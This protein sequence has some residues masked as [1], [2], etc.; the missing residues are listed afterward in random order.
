MTYLNYEKGQSLFDSRND[1]VMKT[2][3]MVHSFMIANQQM[4]PDRLRPSKPFDMYYFYLSL[5]QV[6]AE[7]YQKPIP[8]FLPEDCKVLAFNRPDFRLGS[9]IGFPFVDLGIAAAYVDK[10]EAD[11]DAGGTDFDLDFA[12]KVACQA[13]DAKAI[14]TIQNGSHPMEDRSGDDLESW[15]SGFNVASLEKSVDHN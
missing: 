11:S 14:K 2:S 4:G 12:C 15:L 9:W 5:A 1:L 10:V 8:K 7:F 6:L 3:R 13:F